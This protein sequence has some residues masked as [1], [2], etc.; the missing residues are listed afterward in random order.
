[1]LRNRT[2]TDLLPD[3]SSLIAN[4]VFPALSGLTLYGTIAESVDVFARMLARDTNF[5]IISRPVVYTANNKRA[6]ISSGQEVPVPTSTTTSAISG[7]STALTS[8]IG[9]KDVVLKLEV[10]PLINSE[11]EVTLTIAQQNNAILEFVEISQNRVPV[12]GTQRLT[13][14]ITVRDRSTIVLGG[15]IT[16]EDTTTRSG[17]PVLKDVPGLNYLFGSTSKNK[18][19]RELII[20]I[21]PFI[22]NDHEDLAAAQQSMRQASRLDDDIQEMGEP[23]VRRAEPIFPVRPIN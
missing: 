17:V 14:T 20:L 9:F 4:N 8:N 19:R 18:I 1:L 3:P 7:D 13:T 10:I 2:G 12:I 22:I 21:Q 16:E 6:V 11:D 15:L 23:E 5:K